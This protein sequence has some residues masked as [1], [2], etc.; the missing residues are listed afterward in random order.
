MN[1]PKY[2]VEKTDNRD[3][4]IMQIQDD[5]TYRKIGVMWKPEDAVELVRLANSGD[6]VPQ[7]YET[8][9]G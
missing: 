4:Y 1:S 8:V 6:N 2:I 9:H 7:S 3:A 5:G